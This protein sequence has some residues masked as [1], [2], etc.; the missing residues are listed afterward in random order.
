MTPFDE[1]EARLRQVVTRRVQQLPHD[2][3][4]MTN[5]G[6]LYMLQERERRV[7]SI[8]RKNK[9][10]VLNAGRILEVGCGTGL[11]IRD[12]IRWGVNPARITGVELLPERAVEARRLCPAEVSIHCGN[13][14]T[15]AFPADTFDL[16][17]QSTVFT[18][19]LNR[20]VQ[21]DLAREMLR[22]LKPG[23]FILWYD[24]HLNNPRNPDVRGVTRYDVQRLFPQCHIQL[25][26][27]TLAPPL[28]R[29]LAPVSWLGCH[30][31]SL[32]PF[33]CT[34]YLGIIRKR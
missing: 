14:A 18:S 6:Q 21:K 29:L 31:L 27:I 33:F 30:L 19:I 4:A 28:V 22:V 17:I 34:H 26:P 32:V 20:E 25:A 5:C 23:G 13:A 7:L 11:W 15:L 16:V 2:L 10:D 3:Y 24:F 8:L 1:E 9:S 12:L